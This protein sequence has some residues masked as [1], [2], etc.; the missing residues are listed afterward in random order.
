M[1]TVLLLLFATSLACASAVYD[2][3]DFTSCGSSDDT[4]AFN[5]ELTAIG[6]NNAAIQFTCRPKLS[7]ITIPANITLD[8]TAG[9][10]IY[11][12]TGQRVTILSPMVSVPRQMFYNA[13]AGLG[14]VSFSGNTA[15]LDFY[16]AWWGQGYAALQ[17]ASE[18][19]DS[20]GNGGTLKLSSGHYTI[21]ANTW[22]IA[23]NTS[24]QHKI[25]I[26]GQGPL[27]TYI[28]STVTG[29]TCAIYLQTLK[30]VEL[31]DFSLN[32]S[33]IGNGEGICMGTAETTG[34]GTN[35]DVFTN[36]IAQNFS[37]CVQSTGGEGTSSEITFISPQFNNCTNGFYNAN[38]NGLD[39]NFYQL[40]MANNTVGINCATAGC[41]VYGGSASGNG[42]DFSFGNGGEFVISGFRSE[43]AGLFLT[44]ANAA[45][46]ATVT[47]V[48]GVQVQSVTGNYAIL[49]GPGSLTISNSNIGAPIEIV[50]DTAV[51]SLKNN[52][53]ADPSNTYTA[54]ATPE[55]MGPGFRMIA[56]SQGAI[57]ESTNNTMVNTSFV[58]RGSWPSGIGTVVDDAS[59]AP[60]APMGNYGQS[61]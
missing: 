56:G 7:T 8:N 18:A 15:V 37:N 1:K 12:V 11:V 20:T 57:F 49:V 25:N 55:Y 13:T 58:K 51:L 19:V 47:S 48:N 29:T 22:T 38:Y 50:N 52:N 44:T 23:N 24:T 54:T 42:T 10:G 33:G 61:R 32:G 59:Y 27:A 5:A 26:I 40:Q 60:I 6:S 16:Q 9:G 39:F 31:K 30:Y 4:S 2:V 28:D 17:A 43:T 14:T 21:S 36:I 46:G 53:I 41:N 34:T 35:G 45:T 3:R